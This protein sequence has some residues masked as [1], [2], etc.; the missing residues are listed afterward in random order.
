MKSLLALA[1]LSVVLVG[2]I[3]YAEAYDGKIRFD[4]T[5]SDFTNGEIIHYK[6]MLINSE[7]DRSEAII[8]QL[9]DPNGNEMNAFGIAVESQMELFEGVDEVWP[10]E[11]S[12]DTSNY[13]LETDIRYSVK[14]TYEDKTDENKLF[15]YPSLEQSIV[16]AANAKDEADSMMTQES[17]IPEWVRN[18]FTFWVEKQISDQELIS[19]IEYLIEINIIQVSNPLG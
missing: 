14:A 16:D 6:G 2:M 12:I 9:L 17:E 13:D 15:V 3:G 18:V 4:S 19:A 8:I 5:S 1:L 7:P 10:F 11:F